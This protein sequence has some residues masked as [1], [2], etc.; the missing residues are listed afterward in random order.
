LHGLTKG[1]KIA[2]YNSIRSFKTDINCYDFSTP[3]YIDS[4]LNDV[5]TGQEYA[6]E[7]YENGFEHIYLSTGHSPDKFKNMYWIKDILSKSPPF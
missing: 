6:K 4:D 3:I 1:K 5:I 2:T 7:L